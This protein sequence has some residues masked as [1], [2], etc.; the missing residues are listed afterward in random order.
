L[1]TYFDNNGATFGFIKDGNR[2]IRFNYPGTTGVTGFS[3]INNAGTGVGS[4][5]DA[6]GI[7]RSSIRSANGAFSQVNDPLAGSSQGKAPCPKE[8]TVPGSSSAPRRTPAESIT[9]SSTS[10]ERSPPS[11]HQ[12]RE[13]PQ[14]KARSSAA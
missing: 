3:S 14:A 11:T 4:C 7:Y 6:K 13:P 1:G 12:E 5:T 2:L 10:T 9:A 8:S